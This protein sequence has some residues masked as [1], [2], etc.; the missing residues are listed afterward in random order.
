MSYSDFTLNDLKVSFS[1][2]VIEDVTLF[3]QIPCYNV[4]KELLSLFP[5]FIP[6]LSH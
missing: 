1:I 4:S 3:S 2:K 6:S 5:K